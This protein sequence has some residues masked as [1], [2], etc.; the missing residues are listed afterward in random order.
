MNN[1]LIVIDVQNDFVNLNALGTLEAANAIPSIRSLVDKF[2]KEN[3]PIY[4]TQDTHYEDYLHTQE[5]LKLP[6]EHCHY[7]TDGWRIVYECETKET[8]YNNVHH[9]YKTAF[10]YDD[11]EDEHLDQYDEVIVCGFVSSICVVS[12]IAV[13]K[14]LYPELPVKF[15]AYASAGLPP[16][17]H[18]AA[19]EVLRSMQVE[20]IE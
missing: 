12:N 15:A 10:A 19:I 16:E 13:I 17:N 9:L 7:G 2:L 18:K 3:K 11:W 14:M 6:V 8:E 5:G 4:Y 1:A 20:I